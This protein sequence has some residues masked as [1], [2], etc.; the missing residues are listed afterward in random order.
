MK[1][2]IT[3]ALATVMLA[4]TATAGGIYHIP[5]VPKPVPS[6]GTSGAA[7]AT[8][9]GGFLAFV[10]VLAGYD[11]IRR[12]TCI[13]D[14]WGLGGPGFSEP[15]NEA[16]NVLKPAHLRGKCGVPKAAVVRVRG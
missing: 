1:K 10:A 8:A 5:V 3:V 12:T 6:V 4:T 9:V 16:S 13:G 2:L 11:L 15:Y 7:G 14:P